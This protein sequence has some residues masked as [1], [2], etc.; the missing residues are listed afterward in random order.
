MVVFTLAV[1]FVVEY[2]EVY[3]IIAAVLAVRMDQIHYVDPAN[4]TVFRSTVLKLDKIDVSG[5]LLVL[6]A[7]IQNQKRL[8]TVVNQRTNL[9]PQFA[10]SQFAAAQEIADRVMARA[11]RTLQMVGKVRAGV[12]C[13]RRDQ[14]F[15]VLLLSDRIINEYR[16]KKIPSYEKYFLFF[17][18]K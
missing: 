16:R 13:A 3:R 1:A 7:V 6:N 14:I 11:G 8:R 12:V 17:S 18:I 9:L 2:P 4:K 5:V 15:N 10:G